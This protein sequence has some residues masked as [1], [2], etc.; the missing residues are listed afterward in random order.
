MLEVNFS[1]IAPELKEIPRWVVWRLQG[2]RKVPYVA[3]PQGKAADITRSCSWVSFE[4]A[5]ITCELGKFSGLGFVLSPDDDIVGVDLDDCVVNGRP[6]PEAMAILERIGAAYVELSPSGTGL[7][8]FGRSTGE[9]SRKQGVIDGV[10]AELYTDLRYLTV[11]GN[12]L[13]DGGIVDLNGFVDASKALGGEQTTQE[14][15]KRTQTTQTTQ[16]EHKRTQ[17][18]HKTTQT[19]QEEHKRTQEV[20]KTTQTTQTTQEDTSQGVG[21]L[22]IQFPTGCYPT[23]EGERNRCL[24]ELARFLKSQIPGAKP[25]ELRSFVLAW[26]KEVLPVIGTKEFSET[27]TDF[28]RGWEKVRTPYGETMDSIVKAS[29]LIA[30]PDCLLEMEYGERTNNLIK[31]CIAAQ[32][33]H[34]DKPF[35]LSSRI[36]GDLLGVDHGTAA[37]MLKALVIDEVLELVTA[38]TRRKASEYR[39]LLEHQP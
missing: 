30:L 28:I 18:V 22:N 16:E 33:H 36:A 24:F 19:T 11:T 26:H 10:K 8:A 17:E 4:Q 29:K 2:K 7:R 35:Y 15:H 6:Y 34:N 9:I 21:G 23:V 1:K 32:Q 39:L 3:K 13:L 5:K 20:H 31:I 37:K 25:S 14:E 38:G 12:A 27:W